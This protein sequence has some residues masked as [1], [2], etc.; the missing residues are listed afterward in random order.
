GRARPAPFLVWSG[1]IV[2]DGVAAGQNRS[3]R[4][5]RVV[6]HVLFTA[7]VV[8]GVARSGFDDG[9]TATEVVVAGALLGWYWAGWGAVVRW[10]QPS[11]RW[12]LAVLSGSCLVAVWV[13]ADF[14]WV[15]FAVFVA[16]ATTLAPGPAVAAIAVMA[17]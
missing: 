7:M 17:A 16:F 8:L 15:C 5:L 1:L 4:M 9:V 14:A 3:L 10:R 2:L 12:W 6:Q 11:P 13:S